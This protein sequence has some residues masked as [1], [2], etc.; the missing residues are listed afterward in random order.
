MRIGLQLYTVRDSYKNGEE[1]K[2]ILKKIKELGYEGVEFAGYAGLG[3]KELKEFLDNIS[4]VAISSHHSLQDLEENLDRVIAYNK[5]LGCQ[6]IVCAYGPTGTKAEVDHIIRV[7]RRACG[8][9]KDSGMELIYHNHSNEFIPLAD[10]R[11]PLDLIGESCNL[12][13]D[14][15]WAFHAGVEPC[16]YIKKHES[17]IS[18]IHLKDGDFEGRPCAI[19]EGYN[20]I[21]G[22]LAISE[23]LNT[24]WLIVENDMPA[25]DGISDI[26]RSIRFLKEK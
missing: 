21:K 7:I 4:L 14:T 24:E 1:F 12:E 2:K 11:I 10:G 6:Y 13:L 19:G 22:I 16:H 5:V 9:V 17:R 20:N 8:A 15:Y 25:P 26:T 18:L 23:K 3:A